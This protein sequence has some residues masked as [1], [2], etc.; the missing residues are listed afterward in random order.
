ME[1]ILIAIAILGALFLIIYLVKQFEK[2][3]SPDNPPSTSMW[4]SVPLVAA[5]SYLYFAYFGIYTY[6]ISVIVIVLIM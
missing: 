6:I 4:V 2:P 3:A 5:G 1:K